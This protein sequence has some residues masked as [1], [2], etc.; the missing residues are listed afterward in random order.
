MLCRGGLED[1]VS[2]CTWDSTLPKSQQETLPRS[3]VGPR[4]L[5]MRGGPC[6]PR[7]TAEGARWGVTQQ[8]LLILL[9]SSPPR[10]PP[11][12]HPRACPLYPESFCLLSVSS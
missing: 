1:S 9:G 2:P 12:G 6:F 4:G 7:V 11:A 8:A 3:Q 5:Q 10:L